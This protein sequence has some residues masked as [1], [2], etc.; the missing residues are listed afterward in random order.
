MRVWPGEPNPLGATWD[1]EGTN[2]AIVAPAAEAAEL[3]LFDEPGASAEAVRIRL[4]ERTG[5][6]WHGYLPDVRPGQCYGYRVR[7]SYA[8]AEGLRFNPAKL[9][10]DPRARAITGTIRWND[11]LYGYV[12]GDDREDLSQDGRDSAAA[13]P[14]CVVIDGSFPWEDDEP[15]RTPWQRTVIYE[16]HVKGTTIRHPDVPEALRGTYLGLATDVIVDHLKALGVTAVQLLPV[17]HFVSE[18]ALVERGLANYWGYNPIGFFAPDVRYATGGL[19]QQVT[20]F[21]SMVKRF[22][23]AGVEVI[24]DVVYNHTGEGDRL[25]PTLCYRGID[26]GGYYRLASHDPRHYQN[27]TGTGNT[28]NVANPHALQLVLDSLRY[29]VTEIHVDGFRFDLAP[30]LGRRDRAFDPE[31]R[32]LAIVRQDPILSQVK[33]I[34]EPWDL[35][36]GGYQLGR[37]PL[38]WSEWNDQFRDTVR[39]F[40]RGDPGH[41]GVVAS[42]LAGSSDVFRARGPFASVNFVTCHDGFT[43]HDLVT[44]EQKHNE[45]NGEGNRDGANENFSR[46]WGVEGPTDIPR[47]VNLRQRMMRN[48]L[49]TLAFSQGVPMISHGDEIGRTQRGN[50]NAYCQ[51]TELSWIDWEPDAE[52][53]DLLAFARKVFAIRAANPVF[54]RRRFFYGQSLQSSGAKDVT[55]LRPDGQEMTNGDWQDPHGHVLGV[56]IDGH[57]T[58]ERDERGRLLV[59]ET[60]LTVL[61]GGARSVHFTLP[62]LARPGRWVEVINTARPPAGLVR[63]GGVHLVAHSLVLLT[64]EIPR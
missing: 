36:D 54:R 41:L 42:R 44:Y 40:W 64:H 59:G 30:V 3:C 17:L 31:S 26:N 10:L 27:L 32:F 63:T 45:A 29:W 12:V 52:R 51:D 7:G 37:F 9:L 13:L 39:R 24:L 48:F 28:W 14:K 62:H 57:A 49:A 35:G 47:V 50:N 22:H 33:L 5:D 46:N 2:F 1:G 25:G 34:A 16:C 6:V 19:G 56:L 20:E 53:L 38:G 18:R 43:L 15:P 4:P 60:V 11:S 8:P 23:R 55:W 21:K 58:D 61:N